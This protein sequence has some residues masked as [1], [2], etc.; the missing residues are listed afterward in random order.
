MVNPLRGEV[1][2][3]LD[4]QPHIARLTLGALAELEDALAEDNLAALAGRLEEDR[5]SSNDIMAVLVAGLRG[6]GWT[7]TQDDLLARQIDGGPLEGARIAA[8]LIT[9]AFRDAA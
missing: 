9:L 8:R 1:Q 3:V 2:I 7:G 5:F 4:G 6:G